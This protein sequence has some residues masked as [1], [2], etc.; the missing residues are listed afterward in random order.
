METDLREAALDAIQD[1]QY[2]DAV[3]YI[4]QVLDA[5]PDDAVAMAILALCLAELERLDE[6]E[7]TARR[8]VT[9]EPF[10][11]Y[12]H[13]VQGIV[14]AQ[15]E[16]WDAAQAAA[17]EA[18]RLEPDDPDHH[19]LLAQIAVGR[20]R[21]EEALAH[22]ERGD[23]LRPGHQGCR[24]LRA[25]AL[26]Q[27]GRLVEAE[28]VYAEAATDPLNTFAVAGKGW[29]AL[30]RGYSADAEAAFRDALLF[31][32]TSEWAR[33]GLLASIKSR[34]PVYRRLLR[35]FL[36]MNRR[37]PRERTLLAIGGVLGY[38]VLRRVAAAVP[39]L[40][41]VIWPVLVAYALFVVLTWVADPLLDATL[42]F[43]AEGRRLLS[44]EKVWAG[45]L[46]A[47]VLALALGVGA[48][49]LVG[50]G[51]SLDMLAMALAGFMIPLAAV[52]QCARGWPRWTMAAYAGLLALLI[53][54]GV[55]ASDA[56]AAGGLFMM[57]FLGSVLG[58]WIGF[59]LSN[60]RGRERGTR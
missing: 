25:L 20:E 28:R 48:A 24:N 36:W 9:L 3:G 23:A 34:S 43:D 11:P 5:E 13:W 15:R 53:V 41:P 4:R 55:L 18:L 52:F 17:E 29:T 19:A 30:A 40:E 50:L 58:S 38:N 10:I 8:A 2:E 37:T 51:E 57:A 49:S 47:T 12:T 54:G 31:D 33:Q 27:L 7:S 45:R 59:A 42:S 21:W 35:F 26:Q 60:V 39:V 56:R 22:A 16:R 32:P 14:L 6:A 1:A 44:R 46:V